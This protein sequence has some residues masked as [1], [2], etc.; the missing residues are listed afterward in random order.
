MIKVLLFGEVK[1]VSGKDAIELEFRGSL[2]MLKDVLKE[3]LPQI[4]YLLDTCAFAVNKEYKTLN[5]ELKGDEEVA[6]IPPVGGG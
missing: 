1:R 6:V 4:S 5:Y 2:G 3:S